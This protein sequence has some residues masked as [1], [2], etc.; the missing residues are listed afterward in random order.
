[1]P[2]GQRIAALRMQAGLTQ[3]QLAQRLFVTRATVSKWER[4]LGQ[5]DYP[6]IERIAAVLSVPPDAILSRQDA[7][8]GELLRA[9]ADADS[10]DL[11]ADLNAFLSTLNSRDRSVFVRRYYYLEDHGTI[12]QRYG[13][14]ESNVRTVLMRTR[15]KFKKYLKEMSV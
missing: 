1:M 5:P 13:I 4:E 3:E 14:T 8:L 15:R 6:M 12:A 9:L 7:V 11:L 2:T 10:D